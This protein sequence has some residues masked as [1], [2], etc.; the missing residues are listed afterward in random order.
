MMEEMQ[1]IT[2]YKSSGLKWKLGILLFYVLLGMAGYFFV[3]PNKETESYH[4][5]TQPLIKGDLTMTV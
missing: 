4:Y 3:I 5:V 2:E 1:K